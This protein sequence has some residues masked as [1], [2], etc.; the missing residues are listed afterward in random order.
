MRGS[1]GCVSSG[2]FR[3][4]LPSML[5]RW[6]WDLQAVSYGAL[7]VTKDPSHGWVSAGE[8]WAEKAYTCFDSRFDNGTCPW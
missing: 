7:I 8:S 2:D 1:Y 5:W 3:S 4:S 6:V